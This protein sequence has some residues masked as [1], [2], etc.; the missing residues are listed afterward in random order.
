VR[1]HDLIRLLDE[2]GP[3]HWALPWKYLFWICPGSIESGGPGAGSSGVPLRN[4]RN[5][6]ETRGFCVLTGE[7]GA[8]ASLS[9]GKLKSRTRPDSAVRAAYMISWRPRRPVEQRRLRAMSIES[10]S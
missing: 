7:I 5:A 1:S 3:E 8:T 9:L 4:R 2:P 10:A 6:R